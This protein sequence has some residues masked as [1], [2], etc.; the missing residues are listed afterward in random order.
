[1]FSSHPRLNADLGAKM[2][3]ACT[4]TP[5][6]SRSS[7]WRRADGGWPFVELLA[8]DF[9]VER[10]QNPRWKVPGTASLLGLGNSLGTLVELDE[11]DGA[12]WWIGG[13]ADAPL[14]A[15]TRVSVGFSDPSARPAEGLVMRC[16]RK[17]SSY[18]IAVKFAAA[19]A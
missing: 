9:K 17:G 15:G 12:P 3:L 11:L 5:V 4:E 10:R 8:A 14:P 7:D 18:R 19:A 1:V 2:A 13:N 16:E 6:R